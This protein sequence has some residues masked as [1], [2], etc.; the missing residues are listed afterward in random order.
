MTFHPIFK[1]RQLGFLNTGQTAS[2]GQ[3]FG[4]IAFCIGRA[5]DTKNV[6]LCATST[7]KD[8]PVII[9]LINGASRWSPTDLVVRDRTAG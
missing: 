3:S 4:G 1:K 5:I 9:L 8:G 7:L 2:S 6:D